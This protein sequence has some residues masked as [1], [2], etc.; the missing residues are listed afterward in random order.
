MGFMFAILGLLLTL[1]GLFTGGDAAL[2]ERSLGFN[3]NLWSGLLMLVF[4]LLMLL[5]AYRARS[6]QRKS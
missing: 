3:V 5:F 4:G 1:F 2:Y 6:L